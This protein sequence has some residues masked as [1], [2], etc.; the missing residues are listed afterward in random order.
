MD[1]NLLDEPLI[2]LRDAAL[3][4]CVTPRWLRHLC[5]TGRIDGVRPTGPG[6]R[7]YV[8]RSTVVALLYG[9]ASDT[10]DHDT[11]VSVA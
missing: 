6:G 8:R 10:S 5:G 9:D 2:P 11:T 4:L 1:S 7:W 3:Y